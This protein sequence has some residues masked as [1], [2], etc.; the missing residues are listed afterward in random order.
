MFSQLAKMGWFM[1]GYSN[2]IVVPETERSYSI[3]ILLYG[4]RIVDHI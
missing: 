3:A 2:G 1:V 4:L